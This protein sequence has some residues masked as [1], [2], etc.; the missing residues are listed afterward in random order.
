MI[1]A[2][3]GHRPDKLS[4]D[5]VH[6]L[7]MATLVEL[8]R[9]EAS[10]VICGMA[11]GYDVIGLSAAHELKI[12]ATAAIPWIGHGVSPT[13]MRQGVD[14]YFRYLDMC[15]EH[16]VISDGED[17]MPWFYP[18]RNAWM[19]DRADVVLAAWNGTAGGTAHCV[20]YARRLGREIRYYQW[21]TWRFGDRA[22][23]A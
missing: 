3:T 13:W 9:L 11:P 23:D 20:N 21:D 2:F 18:K 8:R 12:P 7:W 4:F 1:V 19:A 17:Y 15:D 16:V 14:E 10:R 5:D 22:P 6:R